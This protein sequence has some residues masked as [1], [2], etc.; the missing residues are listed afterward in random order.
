MRAG[1]N[2]SSNSF[3]FTFVKGDG[4]TTLYE[5]QNG[6]FNSIASLGRCGGGAITSTKVTASGSNPVVLSVY[7]N[8]TPC[9]SAYSDA[10]YKLAGTYGGFFLN[11]SS[12]STV[13]SW[14]GN[15]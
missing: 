5:Y 10:T 8:G 7:V 2:A 6:V 4:T 14:S 3:Y 15:R 11:G 13:T 9:G 1:S 12:K